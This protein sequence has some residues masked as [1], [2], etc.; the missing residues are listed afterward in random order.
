MLF[1]RLFLFVVCFYVF[2]CSAWGFLYLLLVVCF[3]YLF[4]VWLGVCVFLGG[5]V[6]MA[7]QPKTGVDKDTH[8]FYRSP[9]ER[10]QQEG[11]SQDVRLGKGRVFLC[12]GWGSGGC[13]HGQSAQR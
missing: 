12:G 9:K 8:S 3:V 13:C 4:F 11:R 5:E 1:V 2:I 7:R 10:Q 6:T